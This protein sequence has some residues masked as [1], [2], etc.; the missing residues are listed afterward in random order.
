MAWRSSCRA[1]DPN[2]ARRADL[3]AMTKGMAFKLPGAEEERQAGKKSK[4]LVLT[5]YCALQTWTR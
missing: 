1:L 4:C 2:P 3:D 5:L